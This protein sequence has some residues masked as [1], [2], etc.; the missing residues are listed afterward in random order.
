ML[1]KKVSKWS[2]MDVEISLLCLAIH[3]SYEAGQNMT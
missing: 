3:D 2:N 1:K